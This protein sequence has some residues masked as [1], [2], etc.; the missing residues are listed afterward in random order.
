MPKIHMQLRSNIRGKTKIGYLVSADRSGRFVYARAGEVPIGVIT[1]SV[2]RGEMCEIQTTGEALLYVHRSIGANQVI[3]AAEETEGVPAGAALP[4]GSSTSYTTVGQSL[5]AGKGL[6]RASINLG[7]TASVSSGGGLPAGGTT[8][9]ALVK[10]S[11]TDYDVTWS[12]VGTVTSVGP[13][14][15]MDFTTITGAGTVA[16]GTPSTITATSTN[17]FAGV[18]NVNHSHELD[19]TTLG[20]DVTVNGF[21]ATPNTISIGSDFDFIGD[22][23]YI[24]IQ[25]NQTTQQLEFSYVGPTD[26]YAGWD[27]DA[28]SYV[29]GSPTR[30]GSAH[31]VNFN[32]STYIN[33][34]YLFTAGAPPTHDVNIEL[35]DTAYRSHLNSYYY[36]FATYPNLATQTW[37]TNNFDNYVSWDLQTGGV[38]RE[39]ITSGFSLDFI[40]DT[41]YI[42]VQYN[43]TDD[44][45]EFSYVGP[46]D[47]YAGW[48]PLWDGS[49]VGTTRVGSEHNVD[50][51]SGTYTTVAYNFVSGTQTHEITYDVD[52]TALR[53][54][55]DSYYYDFATYP[56]LATQTWVTNNF[57]D[58]SSWTMDA[59]TGGVQTL[60]VT[61]GTTVNF[62]PGTDI[63]FTWSPPNLTINWTGSLGYTGWALEV[64]GVSRGSVGN[65]QVVDFKSGTYTTVAYNLATADHEVTYDVDTTALDGR[66][67]T[68]TAA[69]A[70]FA[71]QTWVT[72][73]FDDYDHWDFEYDPV[74]PQVKA[75]NSGDSFGIVGGTDIGTSWDGVNNRLTI[76]YS[77]ATASYLGWDPLADGGSGFTRVGSAH[78]V[79]FAG[80]TNITT[81]YGFVAG[82]PAVHTITFDLNSSISLTA[83]T[84]GTITSTGSVIAD[85]YFRSSDTDVILGPLTAGTVYLRPNGYAS[86]TDQS[87]FT[88]SLA[89][90]GTDVYVSGTGATIRMD[91]NG[92]LQGATSSPNT[93]QLYNNTNGRMY[94]NTTYATSTLG[95][96][97]F[98]AN[99]T[100]A[101]LIRGDRS[102]GIGTSTPTQGR[103][104]VEGG[105]GTQIAVG[106]AGGEASIKATTGA[107]Y[108]MVDSAGQYLSLNHY[109]TDD[110]VLAYG[111][112]SVGI[113]KAN[114]SVALD[115]VGSIYATGEVESYDTSDIRLKN[116]LGHLDTDDTVDGLM[117]LRT[118]RYEHK[119]KEGV[120]LGLIAQDVNR[121]IAF[122]ENIKENDDGYLM[123]HYGKM[124]VPLVLGF[125]NHEHRI[126]AL[127][128]ELSELKSKSNGPRS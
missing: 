36:D 127:E 50:F 43:T 111:G 92:T 57:D 1:E 112:G 64:E 33:T 108:L 17:G 65:A 102:V 21:A 72:N 45:L 73:N 6:I 61:S 29:A 70:L 9:Q 48:D 122:P 93:I 10:A 13:G 88:T 101:L 106:R 75:I 84:A 113:G 128:E 69:D 95:G 68:Q 28:D 42:Q 26:F 46:T 100:S 44:R 37:V 59:N 63:G 78:D 31:T 58:Y 87:T 11:A 16:M 14:N 119:H 117:S 123:V 77:G 81:S 107:G 105:T 80:G 71:T 7:A 41:T 62:I 94:F 96:F 104:Q 67:Y 120:R 125:Q 53:G 91:S 56:S 109:V 116:I 99:G 39:N 35:D 24:Q 38:S 52:T 49:A 25:W 110:V 76:N 47:F 89:T 55:L 20:F 126:R 74:T 8:G 60:T 98:Q 27:P 54:H 97:D 2:Q 82:S 90:I 5:E 15:G 32:G 19:E 79:D 114:P 34:T 18:G 83:V 103:L 12:T 23:T 66:Y 118:V 86:S 115:V 121:G 85:T 4:V 40:G 30:V 22:T 3:R 51:I 124:V